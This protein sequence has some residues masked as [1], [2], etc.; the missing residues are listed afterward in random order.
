MTEIAPVPS[1]A[2]PSVLI[3][4]D[5]KPFLAILAQSFAGHFDLVTVTSAKEAAV[6]MDQRPFDIVVCDY[7]MPGEVGL[8]FLMESLRRWPQT[9]RILLTGY[10]NPDLLSRSVTLAELSACL[11]KPVRPMELAQ[12]IHAAMGAR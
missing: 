10:I 1:P 2:K 7:L 11:L 9:R 4:D 8:D 6:I 5:E 12:A 3:V